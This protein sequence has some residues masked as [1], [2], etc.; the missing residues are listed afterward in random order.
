MEHFR[1][2][3]A[4]CM[5]FKNKRWKINVANSMLTTC[6]SL[7]NEITKCPQG[8]HTTLYH[9]SLNVNKTTFIVPIS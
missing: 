1:L 8:K 3:F 6:S 7:E 4:D 9:F 5:D 2:I